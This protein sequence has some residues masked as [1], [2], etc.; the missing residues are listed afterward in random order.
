M[1]DRLTP[2]YVC[3]VIRTRPKPVVFLVPVN[4]V[5]AL[6][7]DLLGSNLLAQCVKKVFGSERYGRAENQSTVSRVR[8]GVS[9]GVGC[10]A[11]TEVRP[12]GVL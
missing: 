6:I 5:E 8:P 2:G 9:N 10:G 4:A 7:L 11:S 3:S 1:I 12:I